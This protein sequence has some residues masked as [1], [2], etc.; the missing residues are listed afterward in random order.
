VRPLLTPG[1][2][3]RHAIGLVLVL[4]CA[5][6]A[7]WQ[8][9][10]AADGNILSYGYA[11]LWPVFGAFVTVIWVRE[12]RLTLRGIEEKPEPVRAEGYRAPL[13]TRRAAASAAPDDD[14]A[15]AAYNEYLANLAERDRAGS[16]G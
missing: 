3:F 16:E 7:W 4:A 1:W 12:A 9:S 14:P 11:L 8:V 15:L 6:L 5:G 2:L 13:I 10:R